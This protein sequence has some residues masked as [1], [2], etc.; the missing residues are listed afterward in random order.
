MTGPRGFPIPLPTGTQAAQFDRMELLLA[1]RRLPGGKAPGPD[2]VHNEVLKVFVK[3]NPDALLGLL[4]L[5]WNTSTFPTRWKRARLVLLFK[6][7]GRSLNDPGSF[8]PISLVDTVAK[9]YERLILYRMEAELSEN[10]GLS[11][12]QFGFTKGVGTMDEISRVLELAGENQGR[13]KPA[14]AMISLDVRNAFNTASWTAIDEAL[15]KKGMSRTIIGTLR[16]YMSRR[17]I[18]VP[19]GGGGGCTSAGNGGS[20]TGLGLRTSPVE[21]LV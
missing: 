10:G 4:N 14:C 16:S 8:R 2:Y 6:G 21:R 1:A 17:E 9:L 15:R 5:C 19:L 7:G 12:W 20:F 13:E 3:E 18:H 11:I